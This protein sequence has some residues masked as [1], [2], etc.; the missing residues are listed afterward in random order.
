MNA[1][2]YRVFGL[3]IV[4]FGLLLFFT[5]RWTVFEAKSLDNNALN[6]RTVID[7]EKIH[8][9]EIRAADGTVLAKSVPGPDHT[10]SRTYPTASLFSQAVGYS[11]VKTGQDAGLE[12]SDGQYLRGVQTGISAIIGQLGGGT[13]VGDNVYT[14]LDPQAQRLAYQLLAGRAGSVVAIDPRTG[15]IKAMASLPSYDDNNLKA[16]GPGI[17]QFND[18]TQAHD[19]PGSTFK[20][21]TTVAAIDSGKFTPNSVLDGK[22]P[23]LV[24]GQPLSNDGNTSWG[25]Q[26]LTVALTQS[27]NTIFAQVAQQVGRAT[28]TTYMKRFGFYSKPPIDLPPAEL[29]T[30]APYPSGS[31]H[32]FAPGSPNEDIGRIGIG[33]GGMLVT[34][35]QMAMVAAAVANGGKLMAP[36]FT[37]RVVNR[38]G[39]TVLQV[40]PTLYSQVMKPSTAQQVAQMMRHVVEE[41]TGTAA[42][43]GGLTVAGKTGTASIGA[44]GSNLTE[45][46]F[47]GFAPV[48][49]PRI[50]V[51][52]TID[53]TQGQFG[54][55]VAAPIAAAVMKL[56]L[57]EKNG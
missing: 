56:I 38:D 53:R 27:I 14:T 50:V 9:G 33:Q 3:V 29:N 22:S 4:L 32:P 26:T 45:P 49:N 34:P 43:L 28:M 10:F 25:P 51:A 7:Q 23:L 2:I 15:A 20:V 5:S 8:S 48:Q 35:L 54:G 30:S 46:W 44:T 41:G 52:V 21:V 37:D 18:A 39:Q 24:S 47:I 1:P 6:A 16:S 19:V 57:S 36:H 17:S 42:N 55:Q 11:Y 31:T 40:K 13:Q 12:L